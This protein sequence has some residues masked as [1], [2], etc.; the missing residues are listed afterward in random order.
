MTPLLSILLSVALLVLACAWIIFPFAV[1]RRMD[2]MNRTLE[3]ISAQNLAAARRQL[4]A[5]QANQRLD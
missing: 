5:E 4:R 1:V 2:K 3:E